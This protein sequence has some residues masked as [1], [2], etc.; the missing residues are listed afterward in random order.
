MLSVTFRHAL[1][2]MHMHL[3]HVGTHA[4]ATAPCTF[5]NCEFSLFLYIYIYIYIYIVRRA[6]NHFLL[7]FARSLLKLLQRTRY[8]DV[9]Y[10]ACNVQAT[11]TTLLYVCKIVM[12]STTSVRNKEERLR[13]RRERERARRAA[14][15]AEEKERRLRQRRQRQS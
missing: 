9:H 4:H 1:T 8:V 5:D 15:T 7:L 2:V 6:V 11:L 3:L 14:E 10:F 13:R 12:E